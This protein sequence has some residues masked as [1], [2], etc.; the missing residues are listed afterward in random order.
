LQDKETLDISLDFLPVWFPKIAGDWSNTLSWQDEG[1]CLQPNFLDMDIHN[2]ITSKSKPA[3]S[4]LGDTYHRKVEGKIFG[5]Q[6]FD[7]SSYKN[8]DEKFVALLHGLEVAEMISQRGKNWNIGRMFKPLI[9]GNNLFLL[10][11]HGEDNLA[12]A[13]EKRAAERTPFPIQ[14]ILQIVYEIAKGIHFLHKNGITHGNLS[15][16][17]VI[18]TEKGK[19]KLTDCWGIVLQELANHRLSV[20]A[21]VA[22]EI[23]ES[24]SVLATKC[25]DVWSLGILLFEMLALSKPEMESLLFIKNDAPSFGKILIQKYGFDKK[26]IEGEWKSSKEI[27]SVFLGLIE[28]CLMLDPIGRMATED[29]VFYLEYAGK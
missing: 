21:D 25:S 9:R 1:F 13:I 23:A 16:E 26:L 8:W 2:L 18:L 14:E 5:V 6:L 22:P 20:K 4:S 24:R 10:T 27:V 19:P 3:K 28:K 29:V 17:N 15:S 11:E 7:I 12:A